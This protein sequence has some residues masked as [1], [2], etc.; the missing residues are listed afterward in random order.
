MDWPAPRFLV[1]GRIQET[2]I[3][4]KRHLQLVLKQNNV[5]L[6]AWWWDQAPLGDTLRP[7]TDLVA[8]GTP[9]W[10]HR[11]A[12]GSLQFIITDAR[13]RPVCFPR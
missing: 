2:R 10:R 9:E 6:Q 5:Q 13:C 1:R 12:W 7:G 3:V 8:V 11:E 4:Q